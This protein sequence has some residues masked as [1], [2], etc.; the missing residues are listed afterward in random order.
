MRQ[1]PVEGLKVFGRII[2]LFLSLRNGEGTESSRLVSLSLSSEGIP[3]NTQVVDYIHAY[4]RKNIYV[5]AYAHIFQCECIRVRQFLISATAFSANELWIVFIAFK[6]AN[7]PLGH[8]EQSWTRYATV[9]PIPSPSFVSLRQHLYTYI[10]DLPLFL[11]SR[12]NDRIAL[13]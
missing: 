13:I 5:Y 3:Y 6:I 1:V 4:T 7:Q 2:S 8:R 10:F 11:R 9:P 12:C